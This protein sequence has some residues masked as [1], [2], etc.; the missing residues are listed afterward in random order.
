MGFRKGERVEKNLGTPS[1]GTNST[2]YDPQTGALSYHLAMGMLFYA[3][4]LFS[5]TIKPED[6]I[7]DYPSCRGVW[8]VK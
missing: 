1:V 8:S 2:G 4:S 6:L 3:L 5:P 7:N